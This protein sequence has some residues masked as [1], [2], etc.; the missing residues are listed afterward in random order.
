M[1][2]PV[3]YWLAVSSFLLITL[4]FG[5]VLLFDGLGLSMPEWLIKPFNLFEIFTTF[6]LAGFSLQKISTI[7]NELGPVERSSKY[8]AILAILLAFFKA[9]LTILPER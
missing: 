7:K 3:Y 2:R 6:F 8:F 4:P 9:I 5:I 1:R